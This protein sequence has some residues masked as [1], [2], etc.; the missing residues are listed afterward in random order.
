MLRNE[1]TGNFYAF[2]E[3]TDK[4]EFQYEFLYKGFHN[5]YLMKVETMYV[6]SEM[7]GYQIINDFNRVGTLTDSN[8]VW[9]YYVVPGSFKKVGGE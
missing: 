1:A 2:P 7:A 8:H 4:E 9:T 5:G 6:N 3:S